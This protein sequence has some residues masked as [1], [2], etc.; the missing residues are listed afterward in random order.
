[1]AKRQHVT[2]LFAVVVMAF[3]T[4]SYMFSSSDNAA[5][6]MPSIEIDVSPNVLTGGAIAPKLGNATA[7]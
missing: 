7:K 5:Q 2:A 4:L 6:R 1:M 3:I